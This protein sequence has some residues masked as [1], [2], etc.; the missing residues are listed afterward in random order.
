[1]LMP[2]P[3][4]VW[5][6]KNSHLFNDNLALNTQ[7]R[8]SSQ[9]GVWWFPWTDTQT[10]ILDSRNWEGKAQKK[11]KYSW[12]MSSLIWRQRGNSCQ[13]YDLEEVSYGLRMRLCSSFTSSSVEQSRSVA[14]W[15]AAD[16][17]LKSWNDEWMSFTRNSGNIVFMLSVTVTRT[18]QTTVFHRLHLFKDNLPRFVLLRKSSNL[19]I[20]IRKRKF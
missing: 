17:H 11:K 13:L 2:N 4:A 5:S 14:V 7:G 6:R 16:S 8:P 10:Q 20:W 12:M 18:T 1:M 9:T 3:S 15:M 19:G